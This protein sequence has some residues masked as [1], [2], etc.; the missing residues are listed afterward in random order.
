MKFKRSK[1]IKDL[2]LISNG[3][4]KD[5]RGTFSRIFCS[6]NLKKISFNVAQGN[7]SYNKKKHTLRGFHFQKGKNS[8]KKILTP[9]Q[10]SI[11]NVVI[12]L[13][14]N[15]KSFLKYE[16]IV[17]RSKKYQSLYV[18]DGC[19]NAY[20]TLENNTIIHYYMGN[21]YDKKSYSGFRYN[22]DFFKIKW[23]FKP[24]VISKKDNEYQNFDLNQL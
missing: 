3:S 7:L 18:P 2:F 22:D 6:K 12:D 23:P 20:L 19:A 11:F 13:R 4:F 1:I 5:S 17:L 14:K 8:E 15:S 21:F 16:K 9:V 24:K 10:G